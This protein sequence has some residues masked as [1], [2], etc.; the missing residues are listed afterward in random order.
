MPPVTVSGRPLHGIRFSLPVPSA[1][2][3]SAVL[4]AGVQASGPTEI[5]EPE[6]CRDHTERMLALCGARIRR[7]PGRWWVERSTLQLPPRYRVPSDISSAAFFLCAA[8][9]LPGSDVVAEGVLLNPQRTGFLDVI[10]RMGADVE[11]ERQGDEPEPWGRVR[12]RHSP[13]LHGC[14]VGA[15]EIPRLLDEIPILTLM[16]SQA[17]GTTVFRRV[18]ELRVKESNRLQAL[19][20]QLAAMGARVIEKG[21]DLRVEGRSALTCPASLESYGDHRMAMTLRLA[22]LLA[23][24]EPRIREEECVAVSYPD[25]HET[26]G[27][28]GR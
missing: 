23:D 24:G 12:V 17:A 7:T 13:D 2:L 14:E 4:L 28:L 8:A 3:K 1:Q 15:G 20:S 18:G 26:L 22:G 5:M 19:T 25:F 6:A 16:A 27:E 10:S 9:V 21:D 11:V